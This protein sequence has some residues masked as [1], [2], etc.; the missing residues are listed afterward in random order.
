MQKTRFLTILFT[1][2]VILFASFCFAAEDS[3]LPLDAQPLDTELPRLVSDAVNAV[4]TIINKAP[5]RQDY[6]GS[7]F[8]V[9]K[10]GKILTALHNLTRATELL[11][12]TKSGELFPVVSVIFSNTGMD[13][14][15]L[16]IDAADLPVVPL[17]NSDSL[18]IKKEVF[19]LK[20]DPG[21]TALFSKGVNFG[22]MEMAPR[23][24]LRFVAADAGRN[25]TGGPLLDAA[26]RAV[27]MVLYF[28]ENSENY[29]LAI[30]QAKPLL[31]KTNGVIPQD[32]INSIRPADN[33]LLQGN[34]AFFNNKFDQAESFYSQAVKEAPDS[35]DAHN[36]LGVIYL[37]QNKKDKSLEEMSR[38]LKLDPSDAQIYNNIGNVY[39]SLG[40]YPEAADA[41]EKALQLG[42]DQFL[43]N[44]NLGLLYSSTG[45]I[46]EAVA[47]YK[48][49]IQINPSIINAYFNLGMLYYFS[50]DTP[51]AVEA[52]NKAVELDPDFATG[53]YQLGVISLES[54]DYLRAGELLERAKI[55]FQ[56]QGYPEMAKEAEAILEKIP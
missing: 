56:E 28:S 5:G 3:A 36:S 39:F 17:G 35:T 55:K 19:L 18:P 29:A 25:N 9:S 16:K 22:L 11:V 52:L 21:Q 32:F 43:V 34:F 8:I 46:G 7:G 20:N 40:K 15:I 45:E 38:A 50:K 26:G 6:L 33:S 12:R 30:N 27:G 48:R 2:V 13:L 31:D 14:C 23:Q 51:K 37:I 49:A 44:F 10:D 47:A 24:Y 1:S 4:V 53:Y 42:P 41:Y 54:K